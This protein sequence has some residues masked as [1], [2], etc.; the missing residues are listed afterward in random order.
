MYQSASRILEKHIPFGNN[1]QPVLVLAQWATNLMDASASGATSW[2]CV[3]YS[4][5][6]EMANPTAQKTNALIY[7]TCPT[8]GLAITSSWW[9]F[10]WFLLWYCIWCDRLHCAGETIW[11]NHFR[12][13]PTMVQITMVLHQLST[14]K[15]RNYVGMRKLW[16]NLGNIPHIVA[17][18]G[19]NLSRQNPH[20]TSWRRVAG[21]VNVNIS[22]RK[23]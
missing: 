5:C 3:G 14:D 8:R 12:H 6:S 20:K 13:R 19:Y 9:W 7:P 23:V 10:S 1:S 4:H 21:A 22:R 16:Y 2:Q 11:V 15:G 18:V 17:N